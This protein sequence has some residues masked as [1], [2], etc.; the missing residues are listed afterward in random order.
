MG[1]GSHQIVPGTTLVTM[2]PFY[3]H[4]TGFHALAAQL[5]DLDSAICITVFARGARPRE[6]FINRFSDE[7]KEGG[8]IDQLTED[9][10]DE[11]RNEGGLAARAWSGERPSETLHKFT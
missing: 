8:E 1:T 7:S 4:N 10:R 11:L 3:P 2:V 6:T 5:P 9:E